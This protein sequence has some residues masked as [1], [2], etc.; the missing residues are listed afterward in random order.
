M[1]Y[2]GLDWGLKYIGSAFSEG[3]F[4]RLGPELKVKSLQ[5]AINQVVNL[6]LKEQFEVLVVGLPEGE[7]GENIF[8]VIGMLRQKGLTVETADETLSSQD[9]L[10]E[11]I[12]IGVGKKNRQNT[13]SAAAATILQRYLD[14]KR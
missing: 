1:R 8:K 6:A 11:M 5:D 4:V 2:L 12:K 7:M 10:R 9:A 13:H 3:D 14:E